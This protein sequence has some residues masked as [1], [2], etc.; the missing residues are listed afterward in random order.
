MQPMTD[1]EWSYLVI[2]LVFMAICIWLIP[3]CGDATCVASHSRHVGAQ[4][5]QN[6]ERTHAAFHGPTA[7]DP[8]CALCAARKRD[9]P[10]P[11]CDARGGCTP[12]CECRDCV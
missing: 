4:L 8:L 5:A 6:A 7:P 9:Q 3:S 1:A 12:S 10:C 11:A 2:A